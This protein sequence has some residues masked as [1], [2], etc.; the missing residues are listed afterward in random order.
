MRKYFLPPLWMHSN[1]EA[2]RGAKAHV[3]KSSPSGNRKQVPKKH[4][5]RECTA[6]PGR[7][8][9]VRCAALFNF[10]ICGPR[11][12]PAAAA[13]ISDESIIPRALSTPSHLST[14]PSMLRGR[15]YRSRLINRS[16]PLCKLTSLLWPC[17]GIHLRAAHFVTLRTPTLCPLHS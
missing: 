2:G 16:R 10:V 6:A 1:P 14:S 3:P 17:R 8:K 11:I 15:K 7:P 13:G 5:I 9:W 12:P 4:C